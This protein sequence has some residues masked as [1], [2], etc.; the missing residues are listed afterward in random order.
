MLLGEIIDQV[1]ETVRR[2]DKTAVINQRILQAVRTMHAVA[3]F[4]RDRTEWVIGLADITFAAN[5]VTVGTFTLPDDVRLLEQVAALDV[6]GNIIGAPLDIINISEVVKRR[7]LYGSAVSTCYQINGGV[8][9]YAGAQVNSFLVSGITHRPTKAVVSNTDGTMRAM[10][11]PAIA[12][13]SDWLLDSMPLAVIDQALGF[14][15]ASVGNQKLA[16]THLSVVQN[17]HI[18]ELLMNAQE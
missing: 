3:A 17:Q 6:Y 10:T 4:P 1:H 7:T 8:S 18:P 5:S 12:G 11:D 16:S 2:P 14:A 9:F 13:Y 15:L